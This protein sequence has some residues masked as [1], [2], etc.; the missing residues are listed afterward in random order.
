MILNLIVLSK[1]FLK[2][3]A[4]YRILSYYVIGDFKDQRQHFDHKIEKYFIKDKTEEIM[5]I[6]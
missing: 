1:L 3:L 5:L 4:I 2:T 6:K